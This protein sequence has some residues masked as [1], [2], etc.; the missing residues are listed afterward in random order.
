M[1]AVQLLQTLKNTWL[2]LWRERLAQSSSQSAW[3]EARQRASRMRVF[4]L[5][6]GERNVSRYR[7]TFSY[8]LGPSNAEADQ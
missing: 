8:H 6:R 4:D 3:C 1:V 2:D 7:Q 5:R